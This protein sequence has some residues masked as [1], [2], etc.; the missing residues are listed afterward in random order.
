MQGRYGRQLAAMAGV[1]VVAWAG[2]ATTYR[3]LWPAGYDESD[4][5]ATVWSWL[6][7][8]GGAFVVASMRL[9]RV[10]RTPPEWRLGMTIALTAPA[11]ACDV[12][13]TL[14]F[15][16]WFPDGG[17][18]DDRIY[19]ALV[20]GGVSAILLVALLTTPPTEPRR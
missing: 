16:R 20:I 6:V 18:I 7:L 3:L 1:S 5:L 11:L 13:T 14:F 8:G 15:H 19:A 9:L 12:L 10:L 4:G 17:P 2:F